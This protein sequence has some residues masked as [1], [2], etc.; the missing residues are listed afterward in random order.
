MH[1][2]HAAYVKR[3]EDLNLPAADLKTY[4]RIVRSIPTGFGVDG[5]DKRDRH[6]DRNGQFIEKEQQS[7]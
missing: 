6:R 3:V 7:V 5:K 2:I 4:E 1:A